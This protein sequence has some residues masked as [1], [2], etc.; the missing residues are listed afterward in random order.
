[1]GLENYYYFR[2]WLKN[3]IF[4]TRHVQNILIE[5]SNFRGKESMLF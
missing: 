4:S 3:E 1:M 5:K 2:T